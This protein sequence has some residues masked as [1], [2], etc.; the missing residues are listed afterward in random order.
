M[1][2]TAPPRPAV[3]TANATQPPRPT[4]QPHPEPE[5][6]PQPEAPINEGPRSLPVQQAPVQETDVPAEAPGA[7]E[8]DAPA[9]LPKGPEAAPVE[10]KPIAS[11]P[12]PSQPKNA[13]PLPVGAIVM[14]V[15][16]MIALSAL[17]VMIYLKTQ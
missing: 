2:V 7:P 1:D 16:C 17:A 12:Q 15:A 14:T 4:P 11:A 8:E 6:T 9:D 5:I 13:V 10:R 3:N